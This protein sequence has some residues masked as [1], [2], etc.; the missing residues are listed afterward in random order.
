MKKFILASVMMAAIL[1]APTPTFAAEKAEKKTEKKTEGKKNSFVGTVKAIDKEKMTLTLGGKENDRQFQITSDT[2]F[3]KGGKPAVI[4][5]VKEGEKITGSYK[6]VD[7]KLN[8]VNVYIG[9]KDAKK[10]K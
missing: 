5:D 3:T 8:L 10:E 7:G 2:R 6:D 1:A 9:G 4:E